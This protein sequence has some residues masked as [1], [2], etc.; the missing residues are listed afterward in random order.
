M[1]EYILIIILF[2]IIIIFLVNSKKSNYNASTSV[3]D[4][5]VT[6]FQVGKDINRQVTMTVASTDN[7][8]SVDAI[9]SNLWTD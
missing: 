3:A 1:K 5:H 9:N 7:S 4:W 6:F 2:L 8:L